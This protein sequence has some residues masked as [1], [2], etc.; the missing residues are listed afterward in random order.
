MISFADQPFHHL[1]LVSTYVCVYTLGSFLSLSKFRSGC[2]LVPWQTHATRVHELRFA[3]GKLRFR[4]YRFSYPATGRCQR[5]HFCFI[6]L[7]IYKTTSRLL[8]DQTITIMHRAIWQHTSPLHLH[9]LTRGGALCCRITEDDHFPLLNH[10]LLQG[11]LVDSL[12]NQ[13]RGSVAL[14]L[15][16]LLRLPK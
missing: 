13:C 10:I 3:E 15:V 2:L 6:C 1:N 4:L 11:A 8:L 14:R 16:V 5:M 7:Y 9:Y 12:R